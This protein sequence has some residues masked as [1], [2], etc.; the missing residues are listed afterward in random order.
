MDDTQYLLASKPIEKQFRS[1]S[2]LRLKSLSTLYLVIVGG[3]SRGNKRE[4]EKEGGEKR[5]RENGDGED[6]SERRRRRRRSNETTD[7]YRI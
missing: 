2:C 7:L 5:K 6:E 1:F 3:E 4:R